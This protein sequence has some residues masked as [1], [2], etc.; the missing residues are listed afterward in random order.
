MQ[1]GRNPSARGA[2][3]QTVLTRFGPMAIVVPAG[4][5]PGKPGP[6][7]VLA[8]VLTIAGVAALAV[9]YPSS[10]WCV[11]NQDLGAFF[12]T[13]P[14]EK[15]PESKSLLRPCCLV[16]SLAEHFGR[17]LGVL[18]IV[19]VIYVFDPGRRWAIT[20]LL[21]VALGAG[22]LA[23]LVKLL[24]ARVRPN[25]FDFHGDV[26][27]TFGEW[28]P[29]LHHNKAYQSFPSAHTATAV[30]LAAVLVWLY[31]RGR[32]MFVAMAVAVAGQRI[33]TGYHYLS[34][35]LWGAAIGCLIAAFAISDTRA[36]RMFA[37]WEGTLQGWRY[38]PFRYLKN[39]GDNPL[40]WFGH[41]R[42]G[43]ASAMLPKSHRFSSDPLGSDSAQNPHRDRIGPTVDGE[44]GGRHT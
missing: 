11:Q 18:L 22:G 31:P 6:T 15:P 7:L 40:Y 24:F 21:G 5:K 29:L 1:D 44:P 12:T 27:S 41:I 8:L 3:G 20:R 34:D 26:F 39:G 37:R 10:K 9:D 33:A 42:P 23:D 43:F 35:T 14:G 17:A 36:S 16:L 25:S 2:K 13:R 38:W 30:G 28:L 19:P 32:W 4:R